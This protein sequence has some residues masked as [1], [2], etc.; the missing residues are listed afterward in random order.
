MTNNP[1]LLVVAYPALSVADR[2]NI[3]QVLRALN[4]PRATAINAH[5]TLV[6]PTTLLSLDAFAM[7]VA[8]RVSGIESISFVCAAEL[9]RFLMPR[10]VQ[11]MS[12]SFPTR[13][14]RARSSR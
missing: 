12:F 8:E 2:A 9:S 4:H 14:C 3:E 11:R 10:R 13:I 7:E 1:T 5:F 6:L